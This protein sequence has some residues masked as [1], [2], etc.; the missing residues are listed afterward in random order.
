[1]L[2]HPKDARHFDKL[3]LIIVLSK[4]V[5]KVERK[6]SCIN[7]GYTHMLKQIAARWWYRLR[8]LPCDSVSLCFNCVKSVIT[9]TYHPM[10]RQCFSI[11]RLMATFSPISVQAGLVSCS[12]AASCLTATT[13]AP[14]AVELRRSLLDI[15]V[16]CCSN[17]RMV[18]IPFKDSENHAKMGERETA[19]RRFSSREVAR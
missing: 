19:S 5:G 11:L 2:Q 4:A 6:G 7:F 3:R 10:R 17:A 15:K 14:V 18:E 12:L 16:D 9:L 1:M 13:L 8:W